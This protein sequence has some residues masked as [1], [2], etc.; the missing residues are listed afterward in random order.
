[1]NR[2]TLQVR[3]GQPTAYLITLAAAAALWFV[4][5]PLIAADD[6]PVAGVRRIVFLG[7]SITYSGQF[8]EYI[9]AYLRISQ[10]AL[11]CEFL[12]HW[13]VRDR[14][15]VEAVNGEQVFAGEPHGLAILKLVQQ[16]QQLLKDAWLTT[17]GHKRPG[18]NQGLPLKEAQQRAK[19]LDVGI[20][21]LVGR[22][23]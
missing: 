7:D 6:R 21:A 11:R 22:K 13:G 23:P 1:M 3:R 5:G 14:G 19:G 8:V 2:P 10:P 16:K 9:E 4:P 20:H 17:T 18:I 15:V 12:R